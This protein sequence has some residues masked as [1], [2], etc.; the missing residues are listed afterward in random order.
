MSSEKTRQKTGFGSSS[1]YRGFG[2]AVAD[3][4]VDQSEGLVFVKRH[5]AQRMDM[6]HDIRD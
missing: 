4:I 6:L 1:K 2:V 3:S 5:H